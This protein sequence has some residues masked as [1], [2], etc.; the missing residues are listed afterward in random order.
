MTFDELEAFAKA[1]YRNREL[2]DALA[3]LSELVRRE[4]DMAVWRERRG[5]VLLDLKRFN[6]AL[7]DFD[8]AERA[9]GSGFVSLGL[10][11]EL[12]CVGVAE[13]VA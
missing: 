12:R 8:E 9:Q 4:P 1:A 2:P 5:Q 13:C 7:A 3:A 11:G 6:E 10:L